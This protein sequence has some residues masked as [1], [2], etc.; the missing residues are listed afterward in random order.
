MVSPSRSTSRST[1]APHDAPRVPPERRFGIPLT[2]VTPT[3]VPPTFASYAANALVRGRALAESG[4]G[5]PNWREALAQ[6]ERTMHAAVPF[7]MRH[8]GARLAIES[9]YWFS[10]S[11][12]AARMHADATRKSMRATIF[13]ARSQG[14]LTH[15]LLAFHRDDRERFFGVVG[16]HVPDLQIPWVL[17]FNGAMAVARIAYGLQRQRITPILPKIHL[18]VENKIDLLFRPPAEPASV[19]CVQ[20]RASR[21]Q[22]SVFTRLTPDVIRKMEARPEESVERLLFLKTWLG[23]RRFSSQYALAQSSQDAMP[24]VAQI[25][26]RPWPSHELENC[27]S[28]YKTLGEF[29]RAKK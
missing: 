15:A 13:G 18:D 9:L 25:G 19:M 7:N 4:R 27:V 26:M 11:I 14:L 10:A 12:E 3:S 1:Q 8:A 6:G 23:V 29:L 20:V 2:L 16:S 5:I 28:I 22:H 21:G 24:V 17:N